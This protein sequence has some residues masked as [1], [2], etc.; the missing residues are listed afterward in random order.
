M[1][2][3]C[4][5]V[6]DEPLAI[7]I[8]EKYVAELPQLELVGK[9]GDALAALSYL[10]NN[11]IDLLFLDINMPKLSG[12]S[13]VKSMRNPPSIIFTTAYPEFAIEGFELEAVDYL[14]KPF[15]FERFLKA[16]NKVEEQF[17]LIKNTMEKEVGHIYIKSDR[18]LFR[19]LFEEIQYLEAYG[20]YV[21]VFTKEK[22][23]LTKQKL[24]ALIKE[25]PASQFLQIHRSHAISVAAIEYLEGNMV[26]V[27]GKN[28]PISAG[29][30]Q[31]VL[32]A[33]G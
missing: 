6:D 30:K 27:A 16:V 14:L 1:T 11:K 25:L 13:L 9:C 31:A 12:I 19:V 32:T 33:L 23:L 5:A 29:Y 17:N 18:K 22:M 10:K 4:L 21:K 3:K 15:S 2:I 20:D 8:I 26:Q 7:K 24:S 28:L